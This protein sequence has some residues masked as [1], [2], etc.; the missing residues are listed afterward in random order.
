M[1]TRLPAVFQGGG[2]AAKSSIVKAALRAFAEAGTRR[3]AV[4]RGLLGEEAR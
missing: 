1:Q 3:A 2:R 4:S